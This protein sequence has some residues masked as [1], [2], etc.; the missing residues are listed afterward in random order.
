MEF[1][2]QSRRVAVM[3]RVALSLIISSI[4]LV[5][6]VSAENPGLSQDEMAIRK[7]IESYVDAFNRG[8][9]AAAASHWSGDGTYLTQ[10]G[11]T[12]KGPA[13][14]RSALEKFFAD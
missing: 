7:A 5:S 9:A 2:C 12:A 4:L 8:D 6:G 11:E 10:T 3:M 14:I 13:K 1:D